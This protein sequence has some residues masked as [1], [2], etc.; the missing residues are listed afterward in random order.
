M[1]ICPIR[2][3]LAARSFVVRRQ[4][5]GGNAV[6][7]H[8]R[9]CTLVPAAPG[10]R[11]DQV[12]AGE[13]TR[14]GA[15]TRRRHMRD[16]ARAQHGGQSPVSDRYQ[17]PRVARALVRPAAH[18]PEASEVPNQSVPRHDDARLRRPRSRAW[19]HDVLA[20]PAPGRTRPPLRASPQRRHRLRPDDPA[21]RPMPEGRAAV[22]GDR[23]PGRGGPDR[24]PAAG[25]VGR[26]RASSSSAPW[27]RVV[28]LVALFGLIARPSPVSSADAG[29]P[30]GG[31]C[32]NLRV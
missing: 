18:T 8:L 27:P 32:S 22:L 17:T 30:P 7:F 29:P 2:P 21:R 20:A 24:F 28:S 23:Q 16:K 10:G 15:R 19:M 9:G 25:L 4:E 3:Y 13:A 6:G 14:D 26:A 5:L 31:T 11:M 12:S 1:R